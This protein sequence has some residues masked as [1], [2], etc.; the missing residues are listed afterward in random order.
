V[1]DVV[2]GCPRV[3]GDEDEGPDMDDFEEEFPVKSPKK[4]H[5]PVAFDV[6]SENGEQP[7]QKWRTGG[8]TLSSFTGSGEC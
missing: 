5:E 4:P 3:E 2:A 8:H 1:R 6:Y 7:P